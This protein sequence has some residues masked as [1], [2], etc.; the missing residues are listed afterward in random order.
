MHY[1]MRIRA[2]FLPAT[3]QYKSVSP[4][5]YAPR[6]GM[7]SRKITSLASREDHLIT[8][9]SIIPSLLALAWHAGRMQAMTPMPSVPASPSHCLIRHTSTSEKPTLN[10]TMTCPPGFPAS[11]TLGRAARIHAAS[12]CWETRDRESVL[13]IGALSSRPLHILVICSLDSAAP[14]L[15]DRLPTIHLGSLG[16]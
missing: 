5:I 10:T 2:K 16:D 12:R 6:P 1:S 7:A 9:S 3:S 8:F 15:S 13:S 11:Q 14:Q 4:C